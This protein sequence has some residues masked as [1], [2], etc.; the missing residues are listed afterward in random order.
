MQR[1]RWRA[2]LDW[3]S[4]RAPALGLAG[5]SF[6]AA[7]ALGLLPDFRVQHVTVRHQTASSDEAVT[8][9]TQLA[10]VVGRNIFLV[11]SQSVA[12][13]ISAIP[14]VLRARVIPHLPNT[15]EIEIVERKPIATWQSGSGAFLVDDQGYL[16][17]EAPTPDATPLALRDTTG[18]TL[19]VGDR[20][21]Q[22]TLLAARE[23]VKALPGAGVRVREVEVGPSGLV[24]TSEA[25]W[26][27]IFGEIAEAKGLNDKLANLASVAE[28]AQ[29]NNWKIAV[30]DLRPKDRPFYQLAP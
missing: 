13:E 2:A 3:A 10:Q 5:A 20:V 19:Q 27:I 8:R 1:S 25:G 28:A 9:A 4:E 30:L 17:A 26:R 29:R 21:N 18:H 11:N 12:Q 6:G 22:R 15:V 16:L 14:S 24:F 23:L 7:I